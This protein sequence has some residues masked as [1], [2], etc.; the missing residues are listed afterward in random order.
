VDEVEQPIRLQG[1]YFDEETGLHYTRFRY[2]CPEIGSFISKDPLKLA[3][4]ENVYAYAPNV[5][6]W[7]DPLG[8][9]KKSKKPKGA[10]FGF[11]TQ[12]KAATA[13]LK[14]A[15]PQSIQDNL[16]YGGLIY[17]KNGQYGY[18]GPIRGT[19]QGVNP[20]NAPVPAGTDVVGDYHTH[21]DYSIA[22]PKTGAAIRTSD[23]LRDDFNSDN[24]SFGDYAGIKQDAIGTP[25]YKGYLGTPS[26]T[27]KVF[28]PAT[29]KEG[30]LP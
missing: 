16:E 10:T 6:R 25:G 7:I 11:S 4:G 14:K 20:W 13:A 26:G 24:F 22:D 3:A 2:Y 15:N 27:F 19:D 30:V 23:P 9:C 12:D 5:Q 17:R 29:G 1:Q 28:E 8:L 18:S 21:A